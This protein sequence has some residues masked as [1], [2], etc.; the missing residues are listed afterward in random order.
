MSNVQ[1]PIA[2]CTRASKHVD[3]VQPL[4]FH[5]HLDAVGVAF[6]ENTGH[7]ATVTFAKRTRKPYI[8][9]GPLPTDE[10]YVFEQLHFHWADVDD[11]GGEHTLEGQR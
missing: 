1:S 11:S 9:G 5:G 4:Q 3:D 7:S 10:Q 2:I 6:I 8:V